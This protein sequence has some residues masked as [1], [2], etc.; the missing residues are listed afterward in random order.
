MKVLTDVLKNRE[1]FGESFCKDAQPTALDV[2]CGA[3][4][5]RR[6]DA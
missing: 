5:I 3:W 4:A 2:G 1:F 6:A